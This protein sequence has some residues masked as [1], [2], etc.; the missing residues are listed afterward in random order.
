LLHQPYNSV[1]VGVLATL[2]VVG[3][4]AMG[5][6]GLAKAAWF[7]LR[8]LRL[9]GRGMRWYIPDSGEPY[10]IMWVRRNGEYIYDATIRDHRLNEELTTLRAR[11]IRLGKAAAIAAVAIIVWLRGQA[12]IATFYSLLL[13]WVVAFLLTRSMHEES[14]IA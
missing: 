4:V 10:R 7:A 11:R 5:S 1:F 3:L 8:W 6:W 2:I 14:T 12:F 13:V 9:E